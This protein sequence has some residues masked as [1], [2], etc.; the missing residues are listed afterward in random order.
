MARKINGIFLIR[1]KLT[2]LEGFSPGRRRS[3]RRESREFA[4]PAGHALWIRTFAILILAGSAAAQNMANWNTGAGNWGSANNWDCVIDGVSS[5]CIPGPGFT[6]TNIGGDITLDVNANVA[7]ILGTAGSLTLSSKTLTATDPLGIQITGRAVTMSGSSVI[8]GFLITNDLQVQNSTINGNV[9]AFNANIAGGSL[10]SLTIANQL[11]AV[12]STFGSNS[13]L[14]ISQP[15][16]ISNSRIG[17][18]FNINSGASLTVG[19]G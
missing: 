2:P 3:P 19:R 14:T 13:N 5:H 18:Q 12:N 6:V 4:Q 7:R 1:K 8:N 16:S 9:E 10:G 17:G 11:T 15:S